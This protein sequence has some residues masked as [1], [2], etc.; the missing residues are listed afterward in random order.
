MSSSRSTSKRHSVC[1]PVVSPS[2]L[3]LTTRSRNVAAPRGTAVRH[4][5]SVQP[6]SVQPRAQAGGGAF[7]RQKSAALPVIRALPVSD[8]SRPR[9]VRRGTPTGTISWTTSGSR[10]P[11]KCRPARCGSPTGGRW[12]VALMPGLLCAGGPR[13]VGQL[14]QERQPLEPSGRLHQ[15]RRGA[16][17]GCAPR[18]C[19]APAFPALCRAPVPPHTQLFSAACQSH[20]DE[21]KRNFVDKLTSL[22]LRLSSHTCGQTHAPAQRPASHRGLWRGLP[23]A[24]CAAVHIV[25]HSGWSC[26]RQPHPTPAPCRAHISALQ[27]PHGRCVSSRCMSSGTQARGRRLLA[28]RGGRHAPRRVT[29]R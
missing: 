10:G 15:G 12:R 6:A 4:R 28:R 25:L 27:V 23:G 7:C 1:P 24:G 2:S 22:R 21:L 13:R 19:A 11:A 20:A 17:G 29:E 26:E 8:R 14:R 3:R 18:M 16:C 9:F 5:V